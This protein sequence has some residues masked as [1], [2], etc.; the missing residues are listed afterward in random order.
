[1]PSKKIDP[2][3]KYSFSDYFEMDIPIDELLT[4]FG[5]QRRIVENYP[6]PRQ[7]IEPTFEANFK[8]ELFQH[9]QLTLLNSET[10][11]REALIAPIMFKLAIYLGTPLRIEYSLR[12]NHQLGGKLDYYMHR[13]NNILVVE[14]KQGDLQRGFTQLAVE[15]IAL[16]MWL[17]PDE[18]PLYGCI[19]VG[20]IWRFGVLDRQRKEVTEDLNTY[21][22]PGELELLLSILVGILES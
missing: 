18:K 21:N 6:L 5:Y 2:K 11:R 9:I 19:S 4:Y 3:K 12:V 15:L 22:V 8:A 13:A 14:A 17:E 1:M 10:A 16:D 7:P 20:D